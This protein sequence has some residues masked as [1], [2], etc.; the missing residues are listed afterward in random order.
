MRGDEALGDEE[1]LRGVVVR[2]RRGEAEVKL[3]GSRAAMY[4]EAGDMGV[5]VR[6]GSTNLGRNE[7][8]S[9]SGEPRGMS[10]ELRKVVLMV[11][12]E[13]REVVVSLQRPQGV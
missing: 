11:V 10:N 5:V 9:V 13:E 4:C 8:A 6:I 3:A 1:V 12:V 7:G 2:M